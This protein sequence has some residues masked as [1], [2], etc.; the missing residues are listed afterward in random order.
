MIISIEQ[1]Q[2]QIFII[3]GPFYHSCLDDLPVHRF[4]QKRK[5]K[6]HFGASEIQP[7]THTLQT[8]FIQL[9]NTKCSSFKLPW[10]ATLK[11][12]YIASQAHWTLCLSAEYQISFRELSIIF[13]IVSVEY[14]QKWIFRVQNEFWIQT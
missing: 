9:N 6:N 10:K 14:L 5:K 1:S 11:E 8:Q 2:T 13:G 12:V 3:E 7:F 4:T